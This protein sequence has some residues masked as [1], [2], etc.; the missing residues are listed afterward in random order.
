MLLKAPELD[1]LRLM[2]CNVIPRTLFFRGICKEIKGDKFDEALNWTLSEKVPTRI[3]GNVKTYLAT[4]T[5][6]IR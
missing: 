2:Q 1:F 5:W 4:Q 6:C 3:L